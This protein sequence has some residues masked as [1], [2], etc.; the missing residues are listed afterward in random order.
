MS[1]SST[2]DLCRIMFRR[3]YAFSVTP[4]LRGESGV[5]SLRYPPMRLWLS[6]GSSISVREQLVTQ[7][8]LSILSG[9]LKPAR[10]EEHTSEL[11]SPMYLVCRLLLEKK[12]Q[13]RVRRWRVNCPRTRGW[14]DFDVAGDVNN[15][16]DGGLL[17]DSQTLIGHRVHAVEHRAGDQASG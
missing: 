14:C 9:D 8:V 5:C 1:G 3:S 10:S 7:V 17:P 15:L 11:Q 12:Q 4:C 2:L 13:P 6:R 16:D